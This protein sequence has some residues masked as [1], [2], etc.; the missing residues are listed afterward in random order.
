MDFIY[1][2]HLSWDRVVVRPDDLRAVHRQLRAEVDAA[3][4]GEGG[5]YFIWQDSSRASGQDT[6]DDLIV[7]LRARHRTMHSIEMKVSRTN[8]ELPL[9]KVLSLPRRQPERPEGGYA[10]MS[11]AP[12]STRL[13]VNRSSP[14][15]VLEVLA[16]GPMFGSSIVE[17]ITPQLD[18]TKRKI[19]SSAAVGI[20]GLTLGSAAPDVLFAFDLISPGLALPLVFALGSGGFVGGVRAMEWLFPPLELLPN[21]HSRTRWQRTIRIGGG[22]LGTLAGITGIVGFFLALG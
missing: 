2:W 1:E 7:E 9:L 8:E 18:L 19:L 3:V 22:V 15:I 4:E 16:P 17:A 21:E 5:E 20:A 13:E 14:A 11:R 10:E 6:V 12:V